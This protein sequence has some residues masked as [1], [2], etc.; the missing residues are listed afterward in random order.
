[1]KNKLLYLIA[2]VLL[3]S[4]KINYG[5]APTLGTAAGFV[6]FTSVGAITNTGI[7]QV[8]GNVGSNVGASTNFGNVNGIM[9][10]QNSATAACST[11]VLSAYNQLAG[12]TATFFPS[13]SLGG[14][15]LLPGVYSVSGASTLTNILTLNAQGN[16]NAVFI[17]KLQGAFSAVANAK[18]KLINGALACNVFWKIEGLTNMSTGVTMRGTIITNNAAINM[19]AGDTLEGRAFTTAG[20]ISVI[21][22]MAYTPI[23]CGSPFLT[24]PLAP[25]L[26]TTAN[27]ALFSSIGPVTNT[28]ATHITGDV[29]TNSGLTTG[30]NPLFVNGVIH[31]I[32][33]LS[34]IQCSSDLNTVYTYLN[35]LSADIE[36]LFPAQFGKNLVL[37]PHTY[38]LNAATALTDTLFLNGEGNPNAV[39]VI[40]IFGALSTSTYSNVVLTNGTKSRNVYWLVNGAVS[41]ND[42]SIFR[43]TIIANNGAINF[44]IGSLLDGRA[45]TTVGAVNVNAMTANAPNAPFVIIPPIAKLV[46]LGDTARFIVNAAGT[47]LTFQWRRGNINLV[48]SANI[49]GV[50]NDTLTIFPV[51]YADTASN[52]NVVIMGNVNPSDTTI[53]VS[54]KINSPII[55]TEPINKTA[56]LGSNIIFSVTTSGTGITY[57]WRR[58][59]V[60]LINGGNIQGATSD[61]L[62]I[63]GVTTSDTASNYN[64]IISGVCAPKDTSNN[65]SLYLN[66]TV[67]TTNPI[68]QT[69][70][71][72]SSARFITRATGSGLTYQW[73]RGN[74]NLV[75]GLN[76]SGATTDTLRFNST[77]I[78]DT[79]TNYNVIISSTCSLKDTSA[80]VSLNINL[81]LAISINPS[82]QTVC[83]GSP[84]RFITKATGSGLTYQWRRGNVNLVNG[85]NISG[86]TTDTLR[87]NSTSI[88][89]TAANYNV[90][91]LS[92]CSLRDTSA[93][94]SLNIN[95][96][97]AI[98]INPSNQTV[99]LGS[100]ARFVTRATGSGLT[101][102]W[103]RGNVNLVNGLNITG[104]TTDTLRFNSITILDTATN[105][106]VI[107]S[108]VCSLRDTSANV[109]LN[110]NL[111]LAISINPNNQT[112]CL[113]SSARFITK[114]SGSGLTYQWRRG[115]VNLANGLNISGVTTDTLRFNATTILDTATNYNVI[116]SSTCS[117]RDTSANVSLNINLPLA[118]S[119]NPINQT[120]CL[121]SS[122]IFVTGSTGSGLTYQWRRG[123]VNLVN[124][125]NISGATTDTLRFNATTILDTATNY[126][127]IISSTCSLRDTSANVSLNISTPPIIITEPTNQTACAGSSVSFT[128]VVSGNGI[129]YQW[130]KGNVNLV[131]GGNILGVNS[132]T[133]IINPVSI[134]D[135]GSNYNLVV[136]NACN[137][138]DSSTN[139]SLTVFALPIAN[140]SSNSPICVGITINLLAQTVTTGTYAWSG[141][142][143]F[144]STVQNPNITSALLADSGIY[145]LVVTQNGCNST[146][147]NLNVIV[148]TCVDI[149]FSIPEGFSPN[150]D[151]INDLFVI[152]GVENY[153]TLSVNIYN[154]WGSLVFEAS[155]Y[156]N[157]W[158]GKSNS[159]VTIGGDDLPIGTY[160]YIIDLG[161]GSPILKGTI[162]LNK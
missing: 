37:T 33:D 60:N 138:T 90:I 122:A 68:N 19:S 153:P 147:V 24:G 58:G 29:G 104:A 6:L 62:K 121:G 91:I 64:V 96:P 132:A 66:N 148:K 97:L 101:Y 79:A 63:S 135:I 28:G 74:V 149:V 55:T 88:L 158:N 86:V 12:T 59:S 27:Y 103:R 4:P 44:A 31:P 52:Y 126:N 23:G 157:N 154:R 21:G 119:I 130:R 117:V 115:N 77:S 30:F 56:C 143:G 75:N 48:N 53:G 40:K 17:F 51:T 131:N 156:L 151:G 15:T 161:N 98:N 160:F 25:P 140:A 87:F 67:I 111:P 124:G 155:P 13:P 139:A 42:Y 80:N 7:S 57:Q 127:V 159:G 50:T 129:T 99:C 2:I 22:V 49:S 120:V 114:A 8:T 69:V 82:N 72:G 142:N 78:L 45:L 150:G 76:I 144:S 16:P 14:D 109:S 92:T 123:N 20:A 1:M 152:A 38:L 34:T 3:F 94:V 146:L 32:P 9:Q 61:T 112:V 89:D 35:A 100:S 125:L 106:N 41:V 95:L 65:V 116:I 11:A 26:G 137:F 83:L 39:F 10:S 46:C 36:L 71:L 5:Q 141:P 118:I 133:L 81:P 105:Y 107:I 85:L 73:R 162:Y 18:V 128:A 43:G 54:L 93:N 108:S 84:A 145:T 70:C 113:G 47:N 136:T 110:I 102:Q 134:T